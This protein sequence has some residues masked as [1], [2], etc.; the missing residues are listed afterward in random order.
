MVANPG[1]C[2]QIEECS[3]EKGLWSGSGDFLERVLERS[4]RNTRSKKEQSQENALCVTFVLV[5]S[6]R[7]I[8]V[9]LEM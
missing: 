2:K 4:G 9:L 6:Q 8:F 3:P 5:R 1:K 7:V